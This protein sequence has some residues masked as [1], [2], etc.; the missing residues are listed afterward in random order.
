VR[1]ENYRDGSITDYYSCL[2]I[3]CLVAEHYG[4]EVNRDPANRNTITGADLIKQPAVWRLFNLVNGIGDGHAGRKS[5]A[6]LNDGSVNERG[7]SFF[8]IACEL[9]CSQFY[10]FTQFKWE[11]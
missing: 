8:Q 2:G 11:L 3:A 1:I 10:Y 9:E 6:Q 7:L 5:L 4:Y